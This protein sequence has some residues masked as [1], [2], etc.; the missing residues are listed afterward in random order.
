MKWNSQLIC[1]ITWGKGEVHISLEV[2]MLLSKIDR[3]A[4]NDKSFGLP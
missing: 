2:S 3:L 1:A 4:R